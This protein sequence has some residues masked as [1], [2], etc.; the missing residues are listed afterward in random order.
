MKINVLPSG[1]VAKTKGDK[2]EVN[3]GNGETGVFLRSAWQKL[4][5]K[6]WRME[7]AYVHI[8]W[9]SVPEALPLT[10]RLW[11]WL[12]R[13]RLMQPNEDVAI[14]HSMLKQWGFTE[15]QET[16]R[17]AIYRMEETGLVSV[18]KEGKKQLKV[19]LVEP[20]P[21]SKQRTHSVSKNGIPPGEDTP[22]GDITL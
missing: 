16:I 22:D 11:L 3:L 10:C 9:R 13:Q 14:R 17:K 1:C 15:S 6:T 21:P 8:P 18:I 19:L 5:S 4:A 7:D 12:W 2:V 20:R